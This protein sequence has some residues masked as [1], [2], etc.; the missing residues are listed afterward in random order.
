MI[1]LLTA[2]CFGVFAASAS[3]QECEGVPQFIG[4]Y[5]DWESVAVRSEPAEILVEHPEWAVPHPI[6]GAPTDVCDGIKFIV[7]QDVDGESTT[8]QLNYVYD[9]ATNRSFGVITGS[10]GARLRGEIQHGDQEDLLT[11]VDFD[12]NVVWTETKVWVSDDEF[13]SE[14]V[15]DFNGDEGRV[16]FRTYRVGTVSN[17]GPNSAVR[18][19]VFDCGVL[20]F[21]SIEDFSIANDETD[22]RDLS[23]P[24]Y[25]IE[26]EDGRLLWDGGLPSSVAGQEGWHGEGMQQ[27]LDHTF[28]EQLAAIDLDM[29]SFDY[30]AFSH[31]HF[32]HVGVANE[33]RDAML[34]I[35][36]AEYVAAFADEVTLPGAVPAL[37]SRL[38]DLERLTLHGDHDVFGDGRVRIL[39]APGH[40]PGHQVLFIDLDNYGPVVLSGDL[41]HF[42]L[43]REQRRV[44][45]FNVDRDATLASME[46]V[47][48]FLQEM[49]AELWIEHELKRFEKLNKSPLWYD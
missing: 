49:G 43:S 28:A 31:M 5:G 42:A 2:V 29:A 48:E 24:C 9:V 20:R 39:S 10:L 27:R 25:V 21:E 40:T 37:Y 22:V 34:L 30:V 4:M 23:V 19:Y 8:S 36:N 18:L 26:H 17:D 12:G 3:A 47:E 35:Q 38:A 7:R 16:W 13:T 6:H 32:D 14:G 41:Y 46:R 15:F 45:G 33:V 44:P 1:R 11:L